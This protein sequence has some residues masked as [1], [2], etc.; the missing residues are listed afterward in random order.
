[1]SSFQSAIPFLLVL[2]FSVPYPADFSNSLTYFLDS[3]HQ[4]DDASCLLTRR[5]TPVRRNSLCITGRVAVVACM[6][7]DRHSLPSYFGRGG[8]KMGHMTMPQSESRQRFVIEPPQNFR[9]SLGV[10]ERMRRFK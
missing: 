9:M 7:R 1:M 6:A 2:I 8:R 10:A 5:F 3:P 4:D